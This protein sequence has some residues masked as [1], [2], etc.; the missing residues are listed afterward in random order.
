MQAQR[1]AVGYQPE[2]LDLLPRHHLRR[3]WQ[4]PEHHRQQ[5]LRR[6][7]MNRN[8]H[9]FIIGM[10]F[11]GGVAIVTYLLVTYGA[12]LRAIAYLR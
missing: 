4:D 11:V 5:R 8:A 1:Q 6:H 3:L 10:T 7:T 2:P 9:D 12:E